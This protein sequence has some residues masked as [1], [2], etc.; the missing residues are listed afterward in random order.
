MGLHWNLEALERWAGAVFGRAGLEPAVAR[1][2]ASRLLLADRM[3]VRTHGL[4]RLPS[5]WSQLRGGHINPRPRIGTAWRGGVLVAE[6]DL[7]L[8]QAS[9]PDILAEA[10][11]SLDPDRAFAAVLIR[12]VSHLGAL[13]T[14]LVEVAEAGRIGF[15]AQVTQPVM[16]PAG[17]TRPAIGN[18]PIAFAAPRPGGPPLVFDFAASR[19]AR[20]K[21]HE[22]ARDGVTIPPDWA[23]GP[24]GEPTTDAEIA[25]AGSILPAADHKGIALAMMVEVLAG[26]LTGARPMLSAGGAPAG[27]GA[28]GFVLAPEWVTDGDAFAAGMSAWIGRYAASVGEHGRIPGERAAALTEAAGRSGIDLPGSLHGRLVELAR[29]AGVPFPA[30]ASDG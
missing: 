3:G 8:G 15:L 20:G 25:L 23:I 29:E 5:Y 4:A 18:N 21:V 11:G 30:A 10:V 12:N 6:A 2:A 13:G 28:F 19:V 27:V 9:V 22:A 16:A 7:A 24:D 14:H 26:A 17:A 1:K